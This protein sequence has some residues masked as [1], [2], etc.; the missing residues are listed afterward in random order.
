MATAQSDTVIRHLRRAVLRQDGA[1]R[2]DGQLLASFLDQKDEAAFEAL[3]RRHGSMVFGVCRRVVGNHHDA[4]DAFQATFLVL[5]RKASSVRPR[6]RVANWLHGVAL[7]TAM[8]AKAMTAKRQRREKQ[9]TEMPEP[10]AAEHDQW[11]DLQPLLDQEL[12]GLPENYRLP[13]LLCDLEGKAIKEAAQ[14]L[15]WPQGTL[16]GRLARGRKLLAKRLASRGVVLS[17]GSL[18]LVVSQNVASAGVPISLM[19][20][21][22][23]A[24][25]RIAAGQTTAAGLVPCKVAL[26]TEGVLKTMFMTKLKN[27]MAVL[28]VMA[29]AIGLGAGFLGYGTAAAQQTP[30]GQQSPGKKTEAVVVPKE[31]AKSDKDQLQGK[32]LMVSC[33]CNGESQMQPWLKDNALL[34]IDEADGKLSCK[35]VFKDRAKVIELF[36]E[37]MEKWTET[38]LKLDARTKPK[39][40]DSTGVHGNGTYLGIYKLD[41][42]T[43]T[44]CQSNKGL[45]PGA[46]ET[47]RPTEFSTKRGDGRSL[48]VYKRQ[49]EKKNEGRWILRAAS[50][51]AGLH[52]EW[53]KSLDEEKLHGAWIAHEHGNFSLIFGPGNTVRRIVETDLTRHDDT[54]TYSVDWSKDPHHLDL[55]LNVTG[56]KGPA[57]QTIMEF[58]EPGILRIEMGGGDQARPKDFTDE[59]I[60]LTRME[61]HPPGSKQAKEDADRETKVA[62]FYQRTGK[63]STAYFYYQLVQVRY[64]GTSF[65]EKAK[66]ELEDLK[67]HR[68][69]LVDGSEVWGPPGQPMQPAAPP[70]IQEAPKQLPPPPP[71]QPR[72]KTDDRGAPAHGQEIHELRQRVKNLESRLAAIEPDSLRN[73]TAPI[74]PPAPPLPNTTVPKRADGANEKPVK[75]GLIQIVGNTKTEDAAIL[76]EIPLR[77]GD[78]VD[79]QA[80]RTAKKNLAALKATIDLIESVDNADYKDI[81]VTVVEK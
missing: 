32:W 44:W 52:V 42:D 71:S 48:I 34:V 8:K 70:K 13:V 30:A 74:V 40:L 35:T 61:K 79:Y 68:T 2:T 1:G 59:A 28:L 78:A 58:G 49:E 76:K 73:G 56:A 23:K 6:E 14:Q 67:K 55:K 65:A 63:F 17:A 46:A 33:E 77:P 27:V 25:C 60:V 54:G 66:Q 72:A 18:A 50:P 22:V 51:A 10:E 80:L 45:P 5:A 43:L 75:V 64:P 21:T 41:G 53:L 11:R 36:G 16:A 47:E 31:P 69:R 24:A 29:A 7:R 62:E 26:L 39:T 38:T 19:S 12:N 4:E 9:V 20:S 57:V 37:G 15:G 3:V 81:R